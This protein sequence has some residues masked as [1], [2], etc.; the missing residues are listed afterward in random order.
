[1]KLHQSTV[2]RT[3]H[4]YIS[5]RECQAWRSALASCHGVS[6]LLV[7]LPDA[8]SALPSSRP[9]HKHVV[10]TTSSPSRTSHT[11]A[12]IDAVAW[13]FLPQS[14]DAVQL[15]WTP[16]MVLRQPRVLTEIDQCLA[17][18]GRVLLHLSPAHLAQWCRSGMA[19]AQALGWQLQLQY[20]GD[21]RRFSLLPAP[22]ARYW[23]APWQRYVPVAQ[24]C[25]QLW[26]K[27][28]CRLTPI[29]DNSVL[30][31]QDWPGAWPIQQRQRT[32]LTR[33]THD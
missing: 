13:P 7:D 27:N 25:V 18:D 28:T 16:A 8:L 20:W 22:L 15:A 14:F 12:L 1:M 17:D 2:V 4:Q 19:Q 26:Q 31:N 24:W 6:A 33:K 11:T 3:L 5:E 10:S 32:P 29:R 21:R 23:V 30:A 9:L